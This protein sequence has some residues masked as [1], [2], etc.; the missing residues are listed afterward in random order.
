MATEA[1]DWQSVRSEPLADRY[2]LVGRFICKF[3][4]LGYRLRSGIGHRL[5]SDFYLTGFVTAEMEM[6]QLIKSYFSLLH[7]TVGLDGINGDL[8]ANVEKR[9]ADLMIDRNIIAHNVTFEWASVD[10]EDEPAAALR[11][12]RSHKK[13]HVDSK[14]YSL[15]RL[16]WLGDEADAVA[17]L[18]GRIDGCLDPVLPFSIERNFTKG[19]DGN[20]LAHPPTAEI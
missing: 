13:S 11:W 19:S 18:V 15:E 12:H 3:E 20:W 2:L 7:H 16:K 14:D 5:T 8:F 9:C 10:V 4:A 6:S 17:A 1:F